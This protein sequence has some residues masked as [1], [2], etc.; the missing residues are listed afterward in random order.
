M[1]DLVEHLYVYRN[2]IMPEQVLKTRVGWEWL[3]ELPEWAA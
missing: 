2:T 3:R 1:R